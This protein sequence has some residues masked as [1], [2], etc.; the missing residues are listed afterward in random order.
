[1]VSCK[2]CFKQATAEQRKQR[3]EYLKNLSKR[4]PLEEQPS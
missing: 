1:M 3:E 2:K 4:L